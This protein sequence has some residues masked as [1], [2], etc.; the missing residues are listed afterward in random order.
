MTEFPSL[1]SCAVDPAAQAQADMW[2]ARDLARMVD[3][4]DLCPTHDDKR[5]QMCRFADE[6]RRR[7]TMHTVKGGKT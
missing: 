6:A 1:P 4:L 7:Q 5:D 2:L 3:A